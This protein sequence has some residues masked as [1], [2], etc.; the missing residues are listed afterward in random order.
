MEVCMQCHLETTSLQ[1]PHSIVRYGRP[2]FSYRPGEPLGSFTIFFDH[3]PGNRYEDDFEIA[4]SAYRLR[5]SQCFLRSNG[6]LTCTT[7]HDPHDIP[8]GAAAMLR[9]EG[10]CRECHSAAMRESVASGQHT[11]AV[12]CVRCHMAKRRTGDVIHAVMTD[13]LI[14]RRPPARDPLAPLAERP[15]FDANQYHG[16][17]VPYYPSPLPKTGDN[18]LYLAV[19]QVTQKSNLAKGLPQLSAEMVRQ[20]PAQAEFYVELGQA[21]L[22]AGNPANA[23]GAFEEAVK[24]KP[25]SPVVSLNLA[26]ALTEA[27]QPAR[28]I[29][30]LNRATKSSPDDALLWYQLGIAHSGAGRGTE[31]IAAFRKS[32]ALDPDLAEAHNLLG[33]A[34]AASGDLDRAGKEFRSALEIHPDLP[35]AQG[36]LGHLLAARG[37]LAEAAFYFA[38]AVHLK[39]N[40]ADMLTNYAVTLAGLKQWEEAQRQIDRAVVADPKSPEAHNFKGS[41]LERAGNRAEALSEFLAALRLR[42]D[43]GVAHLNAAR[44]LAAQGDAAAAERHLRQAANGSDP[45]IRNKAAAA[46][47][48]MGKQ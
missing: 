31:A 17:V 2:P 26:D 6:R 4:H 24:R 35:D 37:E 47:R 7:C 41:L 21:W 22:S 33:A 10:A 42:P 20:K 30:V 18:A 46:L 5:K 16:E 27:G 14:Q 34:L 15:E 1:L 48:Q 43:Y 44:M 19:A 45:N 36:N 3:A 40:D 25:G 11:L 39:P 23:I 9:Y 32:V 13:H 38:R 8:T 12:G 29:E 28:A